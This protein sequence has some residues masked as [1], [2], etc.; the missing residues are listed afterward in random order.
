MKGLMEEEVIPR[1][2][3]E[4]QTPVILHRTLLTV[5]VGESVLAEKIK[6]WEEKLPAH[7][8]L[9]YLPHFGMVR[10]RLTSTG[11][12]KDSL[13]KEIS[14][15]FSELKEQVKEWLVIDE[16]LTLPQVITRLLQERKQTIGT[17][18]SC[19]GGYIAHLLSR[20][21]GSS[22]DYWGSIVSYDNQVKVDLLGVK[23]E[24][25]DTAGA[26]SEEA[27]LQM[28]KGALKQ[29]K[30]DYIIA[31][32]GILGPTGATEQKPLGTVWIAAGSE[33]NLRAKQ[34][35]FRFDRSRNME[36]AAIAALEMLR[37]SIINGL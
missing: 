27:V 21:P 15:F 8:R 29:L 28:A 6:D 17:A 31:T 35:N 37:K 12:E 3:K 10:L 18:E 9:A 24:T 5:G 25:L 23:Q 32:T 33:N 2:A 13:E 22:K 4:F 30:T 14:S 16:D 1:L 26:V 11:N 7:I 36:Q 19:T 20:D 34:F